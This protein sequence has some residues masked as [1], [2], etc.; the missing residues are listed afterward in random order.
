MKSSQ[1]LWMK[2]NP[3]VS[4]TLFS[5]ARKYYKTWKSLIYGNG[6]GKQIW[7]ITKCLSNF[8]MRGFHTADDLYF[9]TSV[10][11]SVQWLAISSRFLQ[12]LNPTDKHGIRAEVIVQDRMKVMYRSMGEKGEQFSRREEFCLDFIRSQQCAWEKVAKYRLNCLEFTPLYEAVTKYE[13]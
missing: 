8:H 13:W 12:W 2:L 6:S 11:W 3:F 1:R 10:A 5:T 4:F 7:V 9:I